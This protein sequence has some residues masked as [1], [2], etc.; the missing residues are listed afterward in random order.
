MLV[1]ITGDEL[2][3]QTISRTGVSVDSGVIRR[4]AKIAGAASWPTVRPGH[5][6]LPGRTAAKALGVG[7]TRAP[8]G[9]E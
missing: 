2:Y 4:M 7:L 6:G 9:T 3:F 8:T 5:G 1:E